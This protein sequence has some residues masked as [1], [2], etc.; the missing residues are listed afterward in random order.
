MSRH[1]RFGIWRFEIVALFRALAQ[2]GLCEVNMVN[3]G[4]RSRC[5]CAK[6]RDIN[7]NK[8][9]SIEQMLFI[10]SSSFSCVGTAPRGMAGTRASITAAPRV[11]KSWDSML[12]SGVQLLD[13]FAQNDSIR[14]R[15][16]KRNSQVKFTKQLK[17]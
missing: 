4:A 15:Q 2:R 1:R 10:V 7:K 3:I 6:E 8:G 9:R 13:R 11:V 16:A 12:Q 17:R 5:V 14:I